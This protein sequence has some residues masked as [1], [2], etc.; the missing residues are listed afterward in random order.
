MQLSGIDA[1]LLVALDALLCERNVTRAARR[2]RM[3]QPGMSH[4]LGRLRAHF[5]DPLLVRS[6]RAMVLTPRAQALAAPVREVVERME[7]V[8]SPAEVFDPATSRR[9]FRVVTTDHVGF[10]LLPHVIAPLAREA[11]AVD[12]EIRPITDESSFDLLGAGVADAVVTVADQVPSGVRR[13]TLFTERFCCLVRADHPT[14]GKRLTLKQYAALPHVLI[15]PR[16]TKGGP[17]D[18]AL[19]EHGLTRRVAITIPNFLLAP[20]VVESSDCVVTIAERIGRR[21]ASTAKVRVLQPPVDLPSY[22]VA[23]IWHEK[24]HADPAHRWF[25]ELVLRAAAALEPRASHP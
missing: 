23:M 16:G 25:R 14:V 17:I 22:A 20:L 13:E 12:L 19:A 8:F 4:A 3:G 24:D 7:R 11:P 15:A 9:S 10:V 18:V 2:L 1:N 21:F 5:G 6:G